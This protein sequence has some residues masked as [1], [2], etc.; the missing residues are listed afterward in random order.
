ML[1]DSSESIGYPPM[2]GLQDWGF[3]DSKF[4]V[5]IIIPELNRDFQEVPQALIQETLDEINEIT[6][7]YQSFSIT[8]RWI[9]PSGQDFHEQ[10]LKVVADC[11][12]YTWQLLLESKEKWEQRLEQQE[13]YMVRYPVYV[14]PTFEPIPF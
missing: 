4:R 7:G 1:T 2:A 8:G 13:L 9:G 14:V 11:P 3:D 12:I 10:A 6:R 5:E